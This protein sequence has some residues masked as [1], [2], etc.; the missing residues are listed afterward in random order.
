MNAL[1]KCRGCGKLLS[2]R[3]VIC[4]QWVRGIWSSCSFCGHGGHIE[5]M[6]EWFAEFSFCPFY[7]CS[8]L[9]GTNPNCLQNNTFQLTST[10]LEKK[11]QTIKLKR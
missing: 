9:C 10:L 5:H 8:C 4:E 7:G 2:A 3:C 1:A 6:R 11:P